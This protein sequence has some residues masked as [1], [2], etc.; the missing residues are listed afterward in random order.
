MCVRAV[1][2][3]SELPF[4]QHLLVQWKQPEAIPLL[5]LP[6][7]QVRTASAPLTRPPSAPGLGGEEEDPVKPGPVWGGGGRRGVRRLWW[8]GP[9]PTATRKCG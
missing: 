7:Q 5:A 2:L 9:G 1:V 8:A 3:W 4:L 6:T